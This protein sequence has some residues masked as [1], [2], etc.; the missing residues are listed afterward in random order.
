[1]RASC[2][3]LVVCVWLFITLEKAFGLE[4]AAVAFFKGYRYYEKRFFVLT[5]GSFMQVV[6][7]YIDQVH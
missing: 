3:H 4:F 6:W 5:L 2:M 1:M 7:N